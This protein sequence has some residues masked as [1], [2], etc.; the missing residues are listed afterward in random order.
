MT[1]YTTGRAIL[2]LSGRRIILLVVTN[3]LKS[4]HFIRSSYS[5]TLYLLVVL[6]EKI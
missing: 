2:V 3:K 5:C 6:V 1:A 4:S